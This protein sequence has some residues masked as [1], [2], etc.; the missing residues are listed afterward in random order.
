MAEPK[1]ATCC[2]CGRR[3]VLHP[4]ARGGHELACASCGAP[5]HSM[6]T[7]RPAQAARAAS[8]E[9]AWQPIPMRRKPK[10][11]RK[12]PFWAKAMREIWEEIEDVFD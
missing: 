11:K 9:P 2:Y 8:H 7:L 3:T 6:K 12:K 10:K 5:L 4:F 1:K